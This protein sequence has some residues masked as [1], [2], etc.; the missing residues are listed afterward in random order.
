[1]KE[2][3]HYDKGIQRMGEHTRQSPGFDL[4]NGPCR[5]EA[6]HELKEKVDFWDEVTNNLCAL[7]KVWNG[8]SNALIF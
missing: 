5:T 2:Q 1:M 8:S 6:L 7:W 3:I 4:I